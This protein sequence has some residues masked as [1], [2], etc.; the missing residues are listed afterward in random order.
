[1]RSEAAR[2][3]G[4][5]SDIRVRKPCIMLVGIPQ[6]CRNL[7]AMF[8]VRGNQPSKLDVAPSRSLTA[9]AVGLAA[10]SQATHSSIM[11]LTLSET[12]AVIAAGR[13]PD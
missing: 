12:S 3:V 5:Q 1:M 8:F 6:A 2:Q 10:G 13:A 4:Y 11:R 7:I 9:R